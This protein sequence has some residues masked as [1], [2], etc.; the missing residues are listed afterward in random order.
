MCPPQEKASEAL[1]DHIRGYVS[2]SHG[3]GVPSERQLRLLPAQ[4]E[5]IARTVRHTPE[6]ISGGGQSAKAVAAHF[7]Y[8]GRQ[9]FEIELTSLAATNIVASAP[10][11]AIGIPP[12]VRRFRCA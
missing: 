4:V 7:K 11:A 5:Q 6:V 12:S 3:R 9:E 1:R 8:I 10:R 2:S